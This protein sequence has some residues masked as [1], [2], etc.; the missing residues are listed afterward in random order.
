MKL[1]TVKEVAEIIRAKPSTVY[2]WAETG[3]IPC[4]KLNGCLRF[5]EDDILA[6]I[7]NCKKESYLEYNNL[8]DRRPRKGG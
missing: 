6:W 3:V 4:F 1:L 2:Q 7:K 8:A 5:S